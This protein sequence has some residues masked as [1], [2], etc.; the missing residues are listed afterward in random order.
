MSASLLYHALG[1]RGYRHLKTEYVGGEVIFTIEQPRELYRCPACG[2]ENVIGRGQ[3]VRRFRTVPIGRKPVYL[4]MAVPRV[5]CHECGVV[6]QVKIGFADPRVTYT[7]AF[8]QYAL[9]LSQYMTIQDVADHLG[10]SWDV[11]KDIQKADLKRRFDKPK[12][13]HLRR[14]AI[15]EIATA[16]GHVYMTIVLDLESGVVVH[17][18]SGKGG[19]ALKDF[20]IRLR[21]SGAKIEA[22]ATDMS[23]AYI[24]AVT[25]HLPGAR[26]VFDRFHVIK[27]YNDKLSDLRRAMYRE[28]TDKMQKDALKGVRWLLLKRQEHLDPSRDEPKRLEE[29]LRLNAPLAT[30]YFLKEELNEIWEQE[31]EETAQALLMEWITYAESTGIDVLHRFAKTLRLHAWGILAYYDH[32][33]STGPLEGTNNKI[34]TMKRQAYGFRDQEFFRLKILGLH[35]TKYALVG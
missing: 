22:V 21:C 8:H 26:L 9:E 23:P 6:R 33:I 34:K 15:D 30:A 20:W 3:N 5:E 2:S 29:A 13:K 27:L 18:G 4:A 25:S 24:D 1:V 10:I 19:D 17:V 28:L 31:D 32:P 7:K 11:I 35:Q 14:I 16:K 12:L